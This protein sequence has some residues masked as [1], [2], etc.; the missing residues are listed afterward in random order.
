MPR[1]RY[2]DSFDKGYTRE[3]DGDG[4]HYFDPDGKRVR[5]KNV[6]ARLN[7]LALPP[8][9][10]DAWYCPYPNGHIQA[11][12]FDVKGRRQYR[13][14]PDFS[15]R[16]DADKHKRVLEFASKLPAIRKQIE[17]DIRRRDMSVERVVAGVVR[18]LDLGKIRVGNS[19][20]ARDNKSFGATTL[21]NRHAKVAGSRIKLEYMG[22]SGKLQQISI[23]DRRLSTIIR[24][25]HD[26]PG[27]SLF[28]YVGDDGNLRPVTSSDVNDYL[29]RHAGEF[30]AKDFRTWGASVIAFG[31]L[32]RTEG[33]I[34]LKAMLTEVAAELGNTPAIARKSYIHPAVIEAVQAGAKKHRS[35][36]IPRAARYI[37]A[38]ERGL[39]KFLGKA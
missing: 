29:K 1:L 13:Y 27:Q 30:T 5:A 38:E 28:Q 15:A 39:I 34:S 9:Y 8:A 26:L 18:L 6:I 24:Q 4:W 35:L 3:R 21:R 11:V 2:I 10:E 20:Y 19:Q 33:T 17:K 7:A 37:S 36:E 22:K 25:C 23:D 12:G 31:A 32:V 16:K 14:H